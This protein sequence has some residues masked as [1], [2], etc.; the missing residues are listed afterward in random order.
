RTERQHPDRCDT[1]IPQVIELLGQ[2]REIA[3]PV[4]G[5]VEESAHM[6]LINDCVLVPERISVERARVRHRASG[7]DCST[8]RSQIRAGSDIRSFS[9]QYAAPLWE[10]EPSPGAPGF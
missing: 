1:E 9:E 7:V 8:H 3:H 2:S 4:A 10:T 5:A 6:N